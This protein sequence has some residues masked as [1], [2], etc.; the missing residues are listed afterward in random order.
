MSSLNPET[1]KLEVSEVSHAFCTGVKPVFELT[2]QL[3]RKVRATANHKFLT[4]RGWKRLDEL[5]DDL[6]A[7]PRI[8]PGPQGSS[9]PKA[10]LALLGH[11]IGDGCTLPC[12]ALQYTTREHDLAETVASLAREVF[13]AR[14]EVRVK[15]ER[16]WYQV[17]LAAAQALARGKRNAV[18]QWLDGLGIFGLR[19]HEK[20]VPTQ[21][22]SA[23][24]RKVSLLFLRHLWATDG[25]IRMVY[26][27]S[28]RPAIYFASSSSQLATDVQS[29]LLRLGINARRRRVTQGSKGRDQHHVVVS[30][31]SDW[32]TF[33][34]KVGGSRQLQNCKR[35]LTIESWLADRPANTNRDVIS[36]EVVA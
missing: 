28:P 16:Q 18:A 8:L 9:L 20:R 19:S 29:L 4:A 7:L 3:G 34:H 6:V 12:H 21:V 31:R 36:H 23:V 15:Q 24:S 10:E 14:L 1:M 5:K 26:G 22:I 13:G 17:Y 33:I 11:L 35:Q 2:T 25:C 32:L 27:K 30:G